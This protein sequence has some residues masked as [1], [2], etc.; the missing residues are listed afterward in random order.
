MVNIPRS[1]LSI[2]TDLWVNV[3]SAHPLTSSKTFSIKFTFTMSVEM[4]LCP[5]KKIQYRRPA[6]WATI[7]YSSFPLFVAESLSSQ[8]GDFWALTPCKCEMSSPHLGLGTKHSVSQAR[9]DI[10]LSYPEDSFP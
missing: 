5:Y 4:A 6:S 8:K 2:V 10:P 9:L 3:S 7:L 1:V